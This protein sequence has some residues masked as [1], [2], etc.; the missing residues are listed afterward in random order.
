[1]PTA[2]MEL[3]FIIK[4]MVI[5][6]GCPLVVMWIESLARTL[7]IPWICCSIQ[8]KMQ[9]YKLRWTTNNCSVCWTMKCSP[10]SS[11]RLFSLSWEVANCRW[12]EKTVVKDRLQNRSPIK[13]APHSY[14]QTHEIL[15]FS[16]QV[17]H[18][19]EYCFLLLELCWF[20]MCL[21]KCPQQCRHQ[22]LHYI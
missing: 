3:A 6:F 13:Q 10:F 8:L 22:C 1:M 11:P 20:N 12:K 15:I 2:S 16:S 19:L 9:I 4:Y 21:G 14:T 18:P 7:L 5:F 17:S